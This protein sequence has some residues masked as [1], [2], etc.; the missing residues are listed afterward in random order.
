MRRRFRLTGRKEIPSSAMSVSLQ[1]I[2]DDRTAVL[3]IVH[4]EIFKE[5]DPTALL[6]LR[7]QEDKQV[8]ILNCGS[9]GD[10]KSRVKLKNPDFQSPS[11]QIRVTDVANRPGL[12]LAASRSWRLEGNRTD[13]TRQGILSF[14]PCYLGD[15]M[16]KI[17]LQEDVHPILY[18]SDKIPNAAAWARSNPIFVSSVLP[19]VIHLIFDDILRHSSPDD[20]EWMAE[21]LIWSEELVGADNRPQCD[22]SLQDRREWIDNLVDTF[23]AHHKLSENVVES[24][25]GSDM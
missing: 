12:L 16:W 19:A 14:M 6:R 4:P 17:D 1:T 15:R 11:C 18:V 8:E 9:V 3:N 25:V 21:W 5:F 24:I 2:A 23:C 7:F 13:G 10:P 20:F 22:S